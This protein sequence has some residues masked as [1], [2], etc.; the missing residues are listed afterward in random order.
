MPRPHR[1][2]LWAVRPSRGDG[3]PVSCK[4]GGVP[5]LVAPLEPP[6][7][8]QCGQP[9]SLVMQAPL[10]KPLPLSKRWTMLYAFL[11]PGSCDSSTPGSGAN[12]VVYQS[13]SRRVAAGASPAAFQEITFRWEAH[14]EPLVD[15]ANGRLSDADFDAISGGTKLGGVPMWMGCDDTP[16]CPGCGGATVL[17]AQ[18]DSTVTWEGQGKNLY[19]AAVDALCTDEVQ[20]QIERGMQVDVHVSKQGIRIESRSPGTPGREGAARILGDTSELEASASRNEI[21]FPFGDAGRAFVFGCAAECGERSG[22]FLW[23]AT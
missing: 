3:R 12:L 22:A 19:K 11:C 23:Q 8:G 21:I 13:G 14:D 15:T 5:D 10:A 18:V 20:A 1:R 2:S 9:M 6:C 4:L 17:Q 7:C 16:T